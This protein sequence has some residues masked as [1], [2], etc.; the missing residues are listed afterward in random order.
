MAQVLLIEDE[1]DVQ[2]TLRDLLSSV[3]G[4]TVETASSFT[5]GLMKARSRTWDLIISDHRLPDG[6]G[7]DI[8]SQ[9][10]ATQPVTRLVLTSAFHDFDMAI[11]AINSARIDHFV[12]K[13][14]DPEELLR[15]V[16]RL[17]QQTSARDREQM[18]MRAF[19][20]VG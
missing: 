8:L 6:M 19:R 20:R 7:L 12:Q 17:L 4:C 14:W 9:I 2:A 5:E 11:R 16:A 13:P 15:L 3:P 18:R 1:P 10:A